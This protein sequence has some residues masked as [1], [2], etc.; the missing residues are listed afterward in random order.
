MSHKDTPTSKRP[1]TEMEFSPIESTVPKSLDADVLK[2]ILDEKLTDH[3]R[4]LKTQIENLEKALDKQKVVTEKKIN[5]IKEDYITLK[6]ENQ[7]LRQKLTKLE[8]FQRQN[9]LKIYGIPEERGENVDVKMVTLFNKHLSHSEYFNNRTFEKAHRLG[10][11]SAKTC[12]PIIVK[13]CHYKHKL[14]AYD[15][16]H[17]LRSES[18]FLKDDLPETMED[19]KKELY[20]VFLALKSARDNLGCSQVETLHKKRDSIVLNGKVYTAQ[21]LDKLP[22]QLQLCNLFTPTHNGTTAFYTKHSPLS[23]FYNAHFEVNG[24]LYHNME[25]YLSF[26]KAMLFEDQSAVTIIKNEKDP[27]VI[28]QVANKIRGFKHDVWKQEIDTI[29]DVGLAAKFQQNEYIAKFLMDT[30]TTTI[31]EANQYDKLCAVGKS[32]FDKELWDSTTWCGENRMGKALMRLRK[33]L[34]NMTEQG[35]SPF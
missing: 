16:S 29:L 9:N 23:N 30:G 2:A 28:K 32:L 17:A 3:I 7:I 11:F 4:P 27:V 35:I 6:N 12:R 10:R 20:P 26:H 19:N 21:L 14:A 33:K 25:Q 1:N 8:F 13:F 15:V 5:N 22:D 31:V 18:V 34:K 24:I